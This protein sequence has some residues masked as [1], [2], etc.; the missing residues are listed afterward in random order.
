MKKQL[1][2]TSCFTS[3]RTGRYTVLQDRTILLLLFVNGYPEAEEF[4]LH[5]IY[6]ASV[7]PDTLGEY[8]FLQASV[9]LPDIGH[10]LKMSSLILNGLDYH[11]SAL[12]E[13]KKPDSNGYREFL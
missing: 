4:L 5:W 8:L 12:A 13:I 9:F 2:V 10:L 3:H 7:T 11:F 6:P 1:S